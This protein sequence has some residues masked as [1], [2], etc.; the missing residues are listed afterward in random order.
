MVTPGN[1]PWLHLRPSEFGTITSTPVHPIPYIPSTTILIRSINISNLNTTLR[2]VLVTWPSSSDHSISSSLSPG[3]SSFGRTLFFLLITR[4][5]LIVTN[6]SFRSTIT[7]Y[8]TLIIQL[9][10]SQGSLVKAEI[11]IHTT[12]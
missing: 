5:G 6:A 2:G 7:S 11:S 12:I 4:A 1:F 9:Y 10:L 8:L 3:G